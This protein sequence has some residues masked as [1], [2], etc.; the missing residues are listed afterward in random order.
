MAKH[1]R[2]KRFAWDAG[3]M[4]IEF[5]QKNDEKKAQDFNAMKDKKKGLKKNE[6]KQ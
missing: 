4:T 5:P 1:D 6:K 2:S 3:D